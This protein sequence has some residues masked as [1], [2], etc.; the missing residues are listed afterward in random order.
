[1]GVYGPW[2][3]GRAFVAGSSW[4][5]FLQK[6]HAY[7][8]DGYVL[9][10]LEVDKG[11]P[12]PA[13]DLLRPKTT[14][15]EAPSEEYMLV[16]SPE[17]TTGFRRVPS[18]TPRV[19][20]TDVTKEFLRGDTSANGRIQMNDALVILNTLF[21][22]G[23]TGFECEDAADANDDGRVNVADALAVL[24]YLYGNRDARRTGVVGEY[25]TDEVTD[26]IGC[27]HDSDPRSDPDDGTLREAPDPQ[28]LR[29]V[30]DQSRRPVPPTP[31]RRG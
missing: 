30:D 17:S 1:M 9:T 29:A 20:P 16:P 22:S 26:G 14:L 3:D 24:T 18:E 6:W 15:R 2:V 10:D 21:G 25:H 5:D 12:P 4:T 7:N 31:P 28:I 23:G 11:F 27:D 19:Q 8:D 13:T